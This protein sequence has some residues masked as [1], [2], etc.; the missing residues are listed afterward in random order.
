MTARDLGKALQRLRRYQEAAKAF[1]QAT[2][3]YR[4]LKQPS[5]ATDS[6]LAAVHAQLLSRLSPAA[7]KLLDRAA[8]LNTQLVTLY[9]KGRYREAAQLGRKALDLRKKVLGENHPDYATSLNNLALLY[10]SMGDYAKALPLYRQ[11]LAI[12][13]KALGENHPRYAPPA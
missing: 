7:R 12:R 5:K 10:Q 8:T 4:Q 9:K 6:R 11:A 2:A 1:G 3:A 13:K